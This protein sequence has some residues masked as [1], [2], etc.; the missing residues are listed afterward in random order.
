MKFPDAVDS[1]IKKAQ[2]SLFSA[3]PKDE[4]LA[5]YLKGSQVHG[6]TNEKS[7]VDFVAILKTEKYLL[8]VYRVSKTTGPTTVPPY[9]IS[10]YI[11]NE[12][13]TGNLAPNRPP[14]P[15]VSRFVKHLDHL[16]L[17]YGVR[18]EEPLFRRSDAKDL[19]VNV[20]NFYNLYLPGYENKSFGFS[21]VIKQVLWLAEAEARVLGAT[22]AHSWQDSV[23]ALPQAHIAHE[24]LQY[25]VSGDPSPEKQNEFIE[26]LKTHLNALGTT[27][28]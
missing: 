11:L 18:P 15:G 5:L 21:D 8:D 9:S 28:S 16:V 10:A 25:R 13:Q 12:L 19:E 2:E 24:A 22:V 20:R 14:I 17:I 27:T 23:A 1:V 7:D 26:R 4:V 3:V 6:L